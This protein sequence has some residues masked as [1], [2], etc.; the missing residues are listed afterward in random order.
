MTDHPTAPYRVTTS[1]EVLKA[2]TPEPLMFDT[3][4]DDLYGSIELA[5][6]YQE[7]WPEVLL[8]RK[9]DVDDLR[10]ITAKVD[11]TVLQNAGYDIST[12]QG[13][14]AG[15]SELYK[16]GHLQ[17]VRYIPENFED[18]LFLARLRYP[19]EEAYGLDNIMFRVLGYD[20]YTSAGLDKKKLQKTDWTGG[21]SGELTD[22]Q[23]LYA[24]IDVYYLPD[25]WH[26]VKSRR[27]DD[28]YRLDRTILLH[29]LNFQNVGMPV[30]PARLLGAQMKYEMEVAELDCPVNANSWKQVRPY[31]GEEESDG[32]ALARFIVVDKNEK[33]KQVRATRKALK[34]LSFIKGYHSPDGRVY[35]KFS[36]TTR[37][38]RMACS[39][40]NLEQIP[41]KLKGLFG[42]TKKDGRVLVYADFSQLE[43]RVAC[44]IIGDRMMEKLLKQGIDLHAYTAE[45]IFGPNFTKEQRTV[46]KACNFNLLYGGSYG[47]LGSILLK[48]FL[49]WFPE[50][51]LEGFKDKWLKLWKGIA[52]WQKQ[53]GKDH[54]N[55]KVWETAL[56]RKYIGKRYTDHLNIRV[57]G[58]G[59][60]VAKLALHK[61]MTKL[62]E[63]SEH[64]L[65]CDFIHDS[66]IVECRDI[67][68]EYEAVTDVVGEAMVYAWE[69]MSEYFKVKD[70]PNPVNVFVG[71][72]WGDIEDGKCIIYEKEF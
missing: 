50:D 8:V 15:D 65:M 28:N 35:G 61:I 21:K 37:S 13:M 67:P 18:T 64:V 10:D 48:D 25:V 51:E 52:A 23:L 39:K 53:G 19:T 6:F 45:F 71:K 34:L 16:K 12:M 69:T 58:S 46:S 14:M 24:A 5:Q 31:I 33:A 2:I 70:L 60:D 63:I 30:D 22:D 43:L 41:R 1:Q 3:E 20:P 55:R 47:M 27:T 17:G 9:P 44:A 32:L 4:T 36:P 62:P 68:E 57:Q 42:F 56:G 29:C 49:M 11:I 66:Y 7:S 38:G 26:A 40:Q 72:N 59:A 54:R